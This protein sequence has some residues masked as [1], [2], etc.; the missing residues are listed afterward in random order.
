MK[1]TEFINELFAGLPDIIHASLDL[2][3]AQNATELFCNGRMAL[4]DY[5]IEIRNF[6]FC[7]LST[8]QIE[9][10]KQMIL[11]KSKAYGGDDPLSNFRNSLR[12]G[13]EPVI[14]IAL[15]I[16]DK[17]ARLRN[18]TQKINCGEI[19]LIDAE[20][21]CY[22]DILGYSV[23]LSYLYEST[24]KIGDLVEKI[25]GYKFEGQIRSIF[26]NSKGDTRVVVEFHDDCK[27]T[28]MLHIFNLEQIRK[29]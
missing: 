12:V 9:L 21:D 2:R 25:K 27:P 7:C 28:G 10:T 8:E 3:G 5:A 16:N 20:T 14:G 17:L 4:D 13:I 11:A 18:L 23:L 22:M 29:L 24:L 15:R 26:K 6:A 1:F 19:Y